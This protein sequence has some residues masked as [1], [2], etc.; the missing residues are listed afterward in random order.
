[1]KEEILTEEEKKE[2]KK[3]VEEV[4]GNLKVMID[5]CLNTKDETLQACS[6][7]LMIMLLEYKNKIIDNIISK[8]IKRFTE[9]QG[10]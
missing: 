10:E 5:N 9:K 6:I 7:P 8:A 2:I 4:M 1:M 3:N